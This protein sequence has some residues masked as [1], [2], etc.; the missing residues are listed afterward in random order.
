MSSNGKGQ[1]NPRECSGATSAMEKIQIQKAKQDDGLDDLSNGLRQL[2]E[3]AVDMA[4]FSASAL[5]AAA[6][7]L[8]L[9]LGQCRTVKRDG[10]S[11]RQSIVFSSHCQLIFCLL[12]RVHPSLLAYRGSDLEI[13]KDNIKALNEIKASLGWRVVYVWIGED[14]CGDGNLPPWSGVTCSQQGDYRVVTE[15]EVY[16]IVGSFPIA[17]TNLLDLTRL[18]LHNNKLTGPIPPQIGQ[19]RHLKIFDFVSW[20]ILDFNIIIVLFPCFLL[21]FRNLRWNKLQ[22]GIPPEIGQL[23]KLTHL[24]LNFNNLKGEI[25]VELANL[26]ELR[27]LYLQ[28][29]RLS[30][31][32]PPELGNLKNLQHLYCSLSFS[33]YSCACITVLIAYSCLLAYASCWTLNDLI[34]DGD[35]FPSLR[36]LYLNDN[37]M[38]GSLPD[39]LANMNNL[40]ILYL[41][42]NKMTGPVTRKLVQ[43]PRLTYLYL[44]HNA[45][46]GG[47]PDGLYK[48][49]FLKELYIEGNQ[50]KPGAKPKG[51][52]KVFE[53]TDA[54][55]LL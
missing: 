53:L 35:V 10:I 5:A 36:N 21:C 40:E 3:M 49:P 37:Q 44:D 19:L 11:L 28:E 26:P 12:K 9:C 45:F 25:P 43:I 39:Q 24:Y 27:Y 34:R 31:E 22:D 52:H 6:F 38:T 2:K 7:L 51:V 20:H 33:L 23:K 29:N 48:H 15:L 1:S 41:S 16:A 8:L 13:Y 42:N 32:V 4:G 55:F 46:T 14:P 18:D 50:L 47:I 54:E 30:G 17:V